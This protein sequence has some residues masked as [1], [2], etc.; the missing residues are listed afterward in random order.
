MLFHENINLMILGYRIL[1]LY[2]TAINNIFTMIK[3][4]KKKPNLIEEI[5]LMPWD[6]NGVSQTVS[7]ETSCLPN[8]LKN[9]GAKLRNFVKVKKLKKHFFYLTHSLGIT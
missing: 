1:N 8:Q 6:S 9:R 3:F 4:D 2:H 5:T 7:T